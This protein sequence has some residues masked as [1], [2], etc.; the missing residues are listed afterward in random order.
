[1]VENG[2]ILAHQMMLAAAST[3]FD[4]LLRFKQEEGVQESGGQQTLLRSVDLR[5]LD[6]K[7]VASLIDYA[8]RGEIVIKL[9]NV[10][11]E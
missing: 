9:E 6:Q 7:A 8:Y 5:N 2:S 10:R 3:Y 11:G 1:M 4:G